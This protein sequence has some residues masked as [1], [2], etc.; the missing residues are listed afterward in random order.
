MTF[1]FSSE[2]VSPFLRYGPTTWK[3]GSNGEIFMQKYP[4]LK[5]LALLFMTWN[6]KKNDILGATKQ[7]SEYEGLLN[8]SDGATRS[9]Q[10]EGV[11]RW[12][13][14]EVDGDGL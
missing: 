13:A 10:V 3:D 2:Y 8:C 11:E 4:F 1:H 5:I 9:G 7:E 12:K 14:C 6:A